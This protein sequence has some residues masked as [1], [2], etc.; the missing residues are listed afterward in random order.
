MHDTASRHSGLLVKFYHLSGFKITGRLSYA[1]WYIVFE[2][3]YSRRAW[4]FSNLPASSVAL[5]KPCGEGI[6]LT[7][8]CIYRRS[9]SAINGAQYLIWKRLLSRNSWLLSLT[10]P[11]PLWREQLAYNGMPQ[12]APASQTNRAAGNYVVE[13]PL[14][15]SSPS[16]TM[17]SSSISSMRRD[18]MTWQFKLMLGLEYWHGGYASR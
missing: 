10:L 12:N 7:S 3:Q 2:S 17:L 8:M 9:V 1:W 13:S 16:C 4:R 15:L 5:K 6:P 18:I 14:L 11:L